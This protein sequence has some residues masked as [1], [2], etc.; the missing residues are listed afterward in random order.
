MWGGLGDHSISIQ[1]LDVKGGKLKETGEQLALT[2]ARY[3]VIVA[4]IWYLVIGNRS[5]HKNM[6]LSRQDINSTCTRIVLAL[7]RFTMFSLEQTKADLMES[8]G[9]SRN[10]KDEIEV[11]LLSNCPWKIFVIQI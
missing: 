5:Q 6:I 9:E 8:M 7:M 10:R 2:S 3:L 4:C 11:T 1:D